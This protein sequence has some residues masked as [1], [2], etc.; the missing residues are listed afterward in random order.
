MFVIVWSLFGKQKKC[1]EKD[2]MQCLFT[3]FDLLLFGICGLITR[4][5]RTYIEIRI[6]NEYTMAI[7][8]VWQLNN[9]ECFRSHE[10][11]TLDQ[12]FLALPDGGKEQ[13]LFGKVGPR[14]K[15]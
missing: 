1:V 14:L 10:C 7:G 12:T 9:H 3:T 2:S 4:L 15:R 5:S 13:E 6:Y 8:Y 11:V